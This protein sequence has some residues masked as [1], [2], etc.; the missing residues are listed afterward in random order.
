M[1]PRGYQPEGLS[2]YAHSNQSRCNH[3]L[4]SSTN[5]NLNSNQDSCSTVALQNSLKLVEPAQ[6]LKHAP[7]LPYTLEWRVWT[8]V[9]RS[10]TADVQP[11]ECK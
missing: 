7:S 1:Y 4:V 8:D 6:G 2:G 5:G 11:T 10:R 9:P 3:L